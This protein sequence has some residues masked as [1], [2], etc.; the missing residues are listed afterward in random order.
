MLVRIDC[1]KLLAIYLGLFMIA[2]VAAQ[3]GT[4]PQ[5]GR[6]ESYRRLLHLVQVD[7][8]ELPVKCGLGAISFAIEHREA[9][10]PSLQM[11]LRSVLSRPALQKSRISGDYRIHY[12]T[13]ATVIGDNTPAMLNP[14]GNRIPGS[15]EQFVDSVISIIT[16]V[17][18]YETATLGY[19][20]PPPDLGQGGGP[21]YDIYIEDL[22]NLYGSTMPEVPLDNR[23]QGARY[24]SF[25]SIDNDFT[26]VLPDS[27]KGLPALRVTL[28]HEFHH[29]IQLGAYAY[30][31]DDIYY[32]EITSTWMEDVLYT[33]VNDYYQY[34]G[35]VGAHFK[36]PELRF[37]TSNGR[38]EYS[39]CVWGHFVQKRFDRDA[40]R[41]SWVET[42]AVR[43]LQAI[44]NALRAYSSSFRVAFAEWTLWNF[45]T[46]VRSDSVRYY[47]EGRFYPLVRQ[48]VVD[49]LPPSRAISDSLRSLSA[50][51]Y[52]VNAQLEN[53]VLILSNINFENALNTNS[54][55]QFPYTYNLNVNKLDDTY[56]STETSIFVKLDVPD[57]S[58][59]WTWGVSSRSPEG[60]SFPNPF[61][62]DGRGVVNIPIASQTEATGGLTIFSNSMDLVYSATVRSRFLLAPGTQVF[63]WNGKTNEDQLVSSGIYI[64][65]LE[66]AGRTLTG[67]IALLRK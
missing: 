23:P 54:T 48:T 21:E 62:A 51:Y 9:L 2:T 56:Q 45:Y 30:W 31:T 17:S 11:D 38:V 6:Q 12:D 13:V 29:A 40:M 60:I 63:Q 58:N 15:H 1:H 35:P 14:S 10:S 36:N 22:G 65:V 16:F 34:L 46:N 50:R 37:T 33:S 32:Y 18:S 53:L 39:R 7:T 24:T 57:R 4:I 8:E 41:R 28:A 27:N 64:Y 66:A 25:I 61:L 49:F 52:Q 47:P 5:S 26:F 67:K 20:A 44:D 55:E 42:R 19:D 59:W 43:P 3:T